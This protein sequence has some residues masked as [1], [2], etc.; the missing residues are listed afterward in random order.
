MSEERTPKDGK[1]Y[2]CVKCS[3]G[4]DEYLACELPDCELENIASAELRTLNWDDGGD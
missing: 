1:P 3:M 2:Y 4:F